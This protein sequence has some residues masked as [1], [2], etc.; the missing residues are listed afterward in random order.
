MGKLARRFR[1]SITLRGPDNQLMKSPDSMLEHYARETLNVHSQVRPIP[2]NV[3][4]KAGGGS[5]Q[6]I[7]FLNKTRPRGGARTL[8]MPTGT[9]GAERWKSAIN[10]ALYEPLRG[11]AN[12]GYPTHSLTF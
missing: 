2:L 4:T 3:T 6:A 12:A 5:S 10:V 11:V 9:G 1:G 7:L 8:K